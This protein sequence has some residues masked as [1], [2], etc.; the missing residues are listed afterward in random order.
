MMATSAR[1]N[2]LSIPLTVREWH[3]FPRRDEAVTS[4]VP[5]LPGSV[6]DLSG[7]A[8]SD[9]EGKRLPAQFTALAKWPDGSVRW[10]LCDFQATV[11]AKGSA[12]YTLCEAKDVA[13]ATPL[14]L[15]ASAE[16]YT[17]TTG[18]LK[19]T[20]K[21]QGFDLLHEVW[22]DR[23]GD[24]KFDARELMA[25]SSANTGLVLLGP[26]GEGRYTSGY[27][28]VTETAVE[29]QGP[30][31]I[32]LR[33]RGTLADAQGKAFGLTYTARLEAFANQSYVRMAVTLENPN[34]GGRYPNM[35]SNYWGLGAEGNLLFREFALVQELN[36]DAYPYVDFGDEGKIA[37]ERLP[38]LDQAY[39][40]QDSSGGE[41][42]YHR[43]HMNRDLRIPLK[44]RGYEIVHEGTQAARGDRFNGWLDLADITWGCA[45]GIR[46]FWQNFPSALE[47]RHDGTL[48]V[49]LWPRFLSD[50]HELMAGEQKTHETVWYF[51]AHPP[52][53][54]EVM[55]VCSHPLT[56]WASA[57]HYLATGE[58]SRD[59]P[60]N[61]QLFSGFERASAGAILNPGHSF[62]TDRERVDEYGWRN[63]GDVWA[64]NERDQTGG[65]R[66]GE[67]MVNHF[68]LEYDEGWGMLLHAVR[69]LDTQA[70]LASSWWEYGRAALLHEADIDIHHSTVEAG[71]NPAWAGGKHTHTEHG[72]EAERA[73]HAARPR[74]HVYGTLRWPWG[75]G[76]G[77]ESG[78]WNDRGILTA[79]YLTGRRRFLDGANEIAKVTAFRIEQE[80]HPQTDVPD[81]AAGHSIQIL[82]DHYL[83]TWD[84]RYARLIDKAIEAGHFEKSEWAKQLP[85]TLAS[86]QL[87]LY[88]RPIGRYL[89]YSTFV[90]GQPPKRALESLLGYARAMAHAAESSKMAGRWEAPREWSSDALMIA[91]RYTDSEEERKRFIALAEQAFDNGWRNLIGDRPGYFYNNAKTTTMSFTGGGEWRY[92]RT[93]PKDWLKPV[94]PK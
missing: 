20:V 39:V 67:L 60:Y 94:P 69:D 72:I 35:D 42:W 80:V 62:A 58:F 9:A 36:L 23:D 82:T 31:R 17:V 46:D 7:L 38:L 86:W 81:R 56:A 2:G 93:H 64:A 70:E 49:A 87:A 74:P 63:F 16:A 26:G 13:P 79:Y 19:F 44:F 51:R 6:K 11:E 65:P 71:E 4:G 3:G 92:Y 52:Y 28:Q 73:G 47:A 29:Y 48:S 25:G 77:P 89:D 84:E 21:K 90:H 59:V 61:E 66:Q 76:G 30:M 88:L 14:K 18:P 24:G 33:I 91:A 40:Y 75:L 68:N 32:G 54:R 8:I 5:L 85:D 12:T 27:G 10:L 22:I 41:N 50:D 83:L 1:A 78:H 55:Q 43:N 57:E 45:V 15:E 37:L 53:P 34:A